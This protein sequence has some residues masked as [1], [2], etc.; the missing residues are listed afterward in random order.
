MTGRLRLTFKT[1]P[2]N[3]SWADLESCWREL[4]ESDEFEAGWLFDHFYPILEPTVDGPCFEGWSA[5]SYLAGATRRL[6]LGLMVSGNTYR[7]PAVL[8]NM[9]ATLDVAS[10]GRLLIGIGAAW[11]QAE[12]DAYGIPF[13]P[14]KIRMDMLEEACQ[15]LDTLLTRSVSS[16]SGAHYQLREA[17]CEPKPLQ[18]PRPPIVI[19][20]AGERRTLN[21][22]A[23]YADHWNYPG[24][25]PLE[26]R[27]KRDVLERHCAAVGRNPE[28]IEISAHLFEP[29]D[30]VQ[31]IRLAAALHEAGCDEVILYAKAPYDAARLR[32]LATHIRGEIG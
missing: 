1:Q 2:Q 5:L 10:R 28:E 25:D 29:F 22:V 32:S 4:D 20:G 17:Y 24:R 13:P 31:S 9:C 11:N 21:I 23:R 6:R 7:H 27:R 18:H 16:F 30:E 15:V 19:G 8:A 3:G 26:L 14:L 12:H